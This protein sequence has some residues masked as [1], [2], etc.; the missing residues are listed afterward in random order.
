MKINMKIMGRTNLQ[1]LQ[2]PTTQTYAD[3]SIKNS[4]ENH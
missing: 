4:Y 1:G 3:L 2:E